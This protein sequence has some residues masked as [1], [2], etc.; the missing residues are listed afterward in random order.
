MNKAYGSFASS[1]WFKYD[2]PSACEL[3]LVLLCHGIGKRQHSEMS[4][5][6]Q[7]GLL[8]GNDQAVSS[9]CVKVT[10]LHMEDDC[11]SE[12]GSQA[13]EQEVHCS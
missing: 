3:L 6:C 11:L 9:C 7:I 13:G 2:E 4:L 1:A 5:L 10:L 8:V 12:E